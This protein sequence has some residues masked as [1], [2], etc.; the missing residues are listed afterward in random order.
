MAF[1]R[2]SLQEL[3]DRTQA[4]INT[5]LPGADARLRRSFVYVLARI[6]AGIAHGIYGYLDWISRQVIPD[7]ADADML[8]VH[9]S[10]WGVN[11]IAAAPATGTV[12][13]T[14]TNGSSIPAGTV[15]QRSDGAQFTTDASALIASGIADV[16]V[17]ASVAGQ[18]GNTAAGV[19]VNLIN[20]LTGVNTTATIQSPGLS[21]GAEAETD[22]SLHARLRQR[23][24][25]TPHGG[26]R[27]DYLAWAKEV[28]GVTRVWAF[29]NWSGAGTVGVFFTRDDDASII[30]DAGEIAA[31]QAHIDTVRPVTAAVTVYAPTAAAQAM[32]IQIEPNTAEVQASIQAELEE[33]FL[34]EAN[35]EDGAGSGTVL[36][37]HI[38]QAISNAAGEFDHVLVSPTANITLSSGQLATLGTI[39]WQAIP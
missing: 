19:T 7:T 18:A 17:T 23:V 11:R 16:V 9:A 25:Q 28:A 8:E 34:S 37:S 22:D 20:A 5:Y 27:H 15:V 26:A 31:V 10:W 36:I 39:T 38:R 12:R 14:G 2:P 6:L 3:I 32:T 1:N 30:P 21:G 29:A 33:L 13:F 35:V 4:D 24:Q